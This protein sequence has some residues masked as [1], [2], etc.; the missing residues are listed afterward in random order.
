MR[1]P[2]G[3]LIM[4]VFLLALMAGCGQQQAQEPTETKIDY[5]TR[6]IT[7]MIP[8]DPGGQS[9]L[10]ARRQ[11]PLLQEFLGQKIIITY[12]AG[13]GGAVGWTEMVNQ[14]PDGYFIGGINIPHIILQPLSRDD[15]GYKTEQIQPVAIFQATPI[16]L[17]VPK[18]SPYNDLAKFI[19]A[20]KAKPGSITIGGSGTHSGHHLATLQLEKLSGATFEYVPFTGAAPQM[21]AFL[22]GHVQAIFGN[23]NDLVQH[24]D[25]MKILAI[26]CSGERFAALP[27]VP[28]FI[29]LGY[30][31]TAS[32]DRGVAV[33]P[34]TDEQI[35]KILEEAF[36]KISNNEAVQEQMIK[37]GFE[38]KAMGAAESAA[39]I[40][41]KTVDYTAIMEELE[42][43]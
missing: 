40:Q 16:G 39:Y 14:K 28:T 3:I 37:E 36:L 19:A 7:Y 12:K 26:G 8:F 4:A 24:Q 20:A 17:A 5:P 23:S 15:A 10:E 25:T 13:G 31:M 41:A 33:P 27:D 21:Q 43:N 32:I 2:L 1:K 22:G 9:D 6:P 38:P 42:A 35:V 29:E 34:G 11:Q 18:D 30:D